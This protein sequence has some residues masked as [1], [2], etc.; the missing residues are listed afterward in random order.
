MP[1]RSSLLFPVLAIS[2]VL[3]HRNTGLHRTLPGMLLN[4]NDVPELLLT[5]RS[6][7]EIHELILI[8]I[9]IIGFIELIREN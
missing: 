9:V 1:I 6:H 7:P 2:L 8:R 4:K 3:S 5:P